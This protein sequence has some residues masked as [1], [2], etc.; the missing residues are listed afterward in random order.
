MAHVAIRQVIAPF[1]EPLT[2]D[3]A[4]KW[5]RIEGDYDDD[6]DTVDAVI[7]EARQKFEQITDLQLMPATWRL[8]IDGFPGSVPDDETGGVLDDGYIRPPHPPLRQVTSI[9]YQDEDDVT[10]VLDTSVYVVDTESWPGR[11]GLADGQDWPNVLSTEPGAVTVTYTAG[12]DFASAVPQRI[13][14]VLRN[15]ISL[16]YDHRGIHKD[17]EAFERAVETLCRPYYMAHIF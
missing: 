11:I 10:T 12:Y 5:L 3:E 6:D 8:T 2:T 4:K 17:T 16:I 13:K 14:G 7:E 9:T 1:D 15:V